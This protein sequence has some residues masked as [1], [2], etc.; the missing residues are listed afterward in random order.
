MII[1]QT[2]ANASYLTYGIQRHKKTEA[3]SGE[4]TLMNAFSSYRADH[5]SKYHWLCDTNLA[6]WIVENLNPYGNSIIDVGCGNGFMLEYYKERFK[7]IAAIDP[8]EKYSVTDVSP[9]EIAKCILHLAGFEIIPDDPKL[10]AIAWYEEMLNSI[11]DE[12]KKK[13]RS[14]KT[15]SSNFVR[16]GVG[17]FSRARSFVVSSSKRISPEKKYCFMNDFWMKKYKKHPSLHKLCQ[18]ANAMRESGIKLLRFPRGKPHFKAIF[19]WFCN[20]YS[21]YKVVLESLCI[22]GKI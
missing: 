3:G 2:D 18:I 15:L 11:I 14:R 5:F 4:S 20:N 9:Q 16:L 6:E 22:N 21:F 1:H 19:D 13:K 10:S 8:N 17:K 7:K 12:P